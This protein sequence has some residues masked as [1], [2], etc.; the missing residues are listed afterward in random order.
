MR[1]ALAD[2]YELDDDRERIDVDA[3]HGFLARE[4]YWVRGRSLAVIERLVRTSTSVV[5]AYAP[6]GSLVGF[7][8][9][10]SDGA[11]MAWLGDVFVLPEHR[12]RG[13]GTEL[14][15]EAVEDPR[16][17]SCAWYLNTSDAH[18]LYRRF[19]FRPADPA[20]TMVRPRPA[21]VDQA[22]EDQG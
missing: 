11:N 19:G 14:V 18:D 22:A 8:R 3:V 10:M 6:D 7:A 4:A 13:I 17:R 1:R 21:V 15:R 2:G 9:V 12:G 5:A 16:F 20:L